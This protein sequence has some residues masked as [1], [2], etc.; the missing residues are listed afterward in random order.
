ML[1]GSLIVLAMFAVLFVAFSKRARNS[2]DWKATVTPLASIIGSGFLVIA[3]LLAVTAGHYLLGAIFV[4]VVLGY[5]CGEA[6]RFNISNIEPLVEKKGS[7]PRFITYAEHLSKIVLG[8]A[9]IISV[10]FYLKLLSAFLLKG[11]HVESALYANLLTTG[12]L[13]FIGAMGKFKGLDRLEAMEESAV[14]VKLAII[15]GLLVGLA[16]FNIELWQAGEWAIRIPAR[17]LDSET[18]RTLFGSLIVIQGFETS[19]F[20]GEKYSAKERI[21][22]MR[23]AQI[24][25]GLIYLVFI[26]LIAVV[27]E[28]HLNVSDT[29]VIDLSRRVAVI[30]PVLLIIAAVMSQFSAAIADTIGSGGLLTESFS[31]KISTHSSYAL[32]SLFAIGLTWLTDVFGVITLASRAFA[33]YYSIQSFEAAFIASKSRSFIRGTLFGLLAVFL[34]GIVIFGSPAE[35]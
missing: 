11:V 18:F 12:I 21:R 26:A 22:T 8:F 32:V 35:V 34:L 9:Y 5:F 31:N 30:L 1:K 10:T 24:F 4:L 19:R 28:P 14:N 13:V 2:R 16:Y 17:E 3:P 15:A 27:F 20:L 7:G 23:V 25:S 29:E 33:L 6:I